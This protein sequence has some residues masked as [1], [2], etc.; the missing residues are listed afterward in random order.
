MAAEN[1]AA[2]GFRPK[3]PRASAAPPCGDG[4]LVPGGTAATAAGEPFAAE[5]ATEFDGLVHA[6]S[7][8]D[9]ITLPPRRPAG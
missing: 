8:L 9:V 1:I 4:C 7:D 3:P 2:A 5:A 6:A